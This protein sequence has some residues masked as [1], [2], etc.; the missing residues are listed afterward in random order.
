[1]YGGAHA[2][3][4]LRW[5]YDLTA[6]HLRLD[7]AESAAHA[8][9]VGGVVRIELLARDR[10]VEVDFELS[11]DGQQRPGRGAGGKEA[12]RAAFVDVLEISIPF[13]DLGHSPG[14]KVA[15]AIHVLRAAVEVERMPRY[16]FVNLVVPGADFEGENWRV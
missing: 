12:G 4:N 2:F 5:G 6:L 3:L 11:G 7:P 9:E 1:M 13:A 16:G 15:L 14:D 10:Q 8:L